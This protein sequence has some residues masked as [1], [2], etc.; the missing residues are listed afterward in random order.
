MRNHLGI[1]D[2]PGLPEQ[3]LVH[4]AENEIGWEAMQEETAD[5][6][7]LPGQWRVQCSALSR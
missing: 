6:G 4:A 2:L 1:Q 5:V 7:T 3:F